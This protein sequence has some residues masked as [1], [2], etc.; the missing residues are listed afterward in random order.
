MDEGHA[1]SNLKLDINS[2]AGP[3]RFWCANHA[4]IAEPRLTAMPHGFAADGC[5]EEN[6]FAHLDGGSARRFGEVGR[7]A[8]MVH[9]H[10]A[11]RRRRDYAA[12]KSRRGGRSS[13]SIKLPS[14]E[15]AGTLWQWFW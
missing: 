14:T 8:W 6:L 15:V 9:S 7:T 11:E 1:V 5:S 12:P 4:G 13:H 2:A 10:L 3:E